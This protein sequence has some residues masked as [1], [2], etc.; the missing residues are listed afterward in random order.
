MTEQR[1]PSNLVMEINPK[2]LKSKVLQRLVREVQN[3][4]ISGSPHY[5]D[6]VHNRHARS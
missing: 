1:R 6:R 2:D 4:A 5:Y 3:D